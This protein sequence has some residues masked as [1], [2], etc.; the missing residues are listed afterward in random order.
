MQG[1]L[2]QA[3]A[4][5]IEVLNLTALSLDSVVMCNHLCNFC[6]VWIASN[7]VTEAGTPRKTAKTRIRMSQ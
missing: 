4:Q 2:A 6:E 1:R 7:Y 3:Q 5:L